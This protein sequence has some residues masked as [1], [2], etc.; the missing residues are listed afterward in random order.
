MPL[1]EK[2]NGVLEET[3]TKEIGENVFEQAV[4]GEKQ[5]NHRSKRINS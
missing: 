3:L 5:G 4:A 2:P 1:E